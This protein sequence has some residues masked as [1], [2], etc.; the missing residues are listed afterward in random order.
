MSRR[1]NKEKNIRVLNTTG[2]SSYF[3]TLPIDFVEKFNW[4]KGQK[5]EVTQSGKKL[6]IT[7]WDPDKR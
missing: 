4:R 2:G 5:L 1:P 7:E 3:I 6:I